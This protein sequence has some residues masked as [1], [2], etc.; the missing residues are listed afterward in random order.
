M[1]LVAH[2]AFW[3][4]FIPKQ[5]NLSTPGLRPCEKIHRSEKF[6]EQVRKLNICHFCQKGQ[7]NFNQLSPITLALK[8]L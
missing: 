7:K 5:K 8:I 1:Y 6:S 4:L 3:T 2:K